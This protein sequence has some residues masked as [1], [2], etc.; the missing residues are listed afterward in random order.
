VH[1]FDRVALRVAL[2]IRF[3][4]ATMQGKAVGTWV[5][6]AIVFQVDPE[7]IAPHRDWD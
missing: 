1:E 5:E 6:F 4:P 2:S 3:V 7:G